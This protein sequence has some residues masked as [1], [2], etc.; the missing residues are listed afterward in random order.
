MCGG[1]GGGVGGEA[2]RKLIRHKSGATTCIIHLSLRLHLFLTIRPL[3]VKERVTQEHPNIPQLSYFHFID[4]FL[5]VYTVYCSHSNILARFILLG[6]I[7]IIMV[8]IKKQ[9]TTNV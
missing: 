4:T 1:V 8:F 7:I 9:S 2:G 6:L 5:I 3:E